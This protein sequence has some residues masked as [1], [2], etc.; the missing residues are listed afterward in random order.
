M[1]K[2]WIPFA[3]PLISFLCGETEAVYDPLLITHQRFFSEDAENRS[4]LGIS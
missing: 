4:S 3:K 2:A 1:D